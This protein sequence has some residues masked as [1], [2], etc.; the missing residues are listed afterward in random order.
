MC[1]ELENGTAEGAACCARL[2][3]LDA[4]EAAGRSRKDDNLDTSEGVEGRDRF[5]LADD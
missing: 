4:G 5:G 2:G 1:L 3:V